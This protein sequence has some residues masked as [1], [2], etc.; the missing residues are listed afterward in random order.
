[1]LS[2][3]VGPERRPEEVGVSS[4]RLAKALEILDAWVERGQVPGVAAVAVRR[5]VVV[6]RHF[7]G[8][9]AASDP[10]QGEPVPI[11]RETI[12]PLGSVTKPI[13]ATAFMLLVEA[14]EAILDD[15]V[16]RFVP[17]FGRFG[18]EQVLLRHLLTHTS[19]LPDTLPN[20]E[21]LRRTHSSLRAF[22]RAA[23][24]QDLAF[25][26]GTRVSYSST[27]FL[28]LTEVA[29]RVAGQAFAD[30]AAEQVFRPLAL[31]SMGF[32]PPEALYPWIARLRLP[33]GRVPTDWDNNSP[34][35]RQLGAP[36][37]GVFATADDVARF[38]QSFLEA[39]RSAGAARPGGA[40][41]VLGP[42]TAR[43]MA[44]NHT[45]D[46][47]GVS[48]TPEAWG[49]G[50]ALP[51]GQPGR[52]AGDLAS[53]ETFGHLGAGRTMLWIDPVRELVC[54]V[55]TNQVTNG[56]TPYRR[57]AGFSNALQAALVG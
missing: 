27:G 10:G 37:G 12:F 4:A 48:G 25:T 43:L 31:R 53:P 57:F 26:P 20:N 51:A 33:E 8:W 14:G 22:V 40:G 55:L 34:Y 30:F 19:G 45:R 13:A 28:M 38:G 47:P 46:I 36:W 24:R 42:A 44:Q 29:E 15:P 6:A 21:S 17:E 50:W 32:R 52:W 54:V 9:A 5:G 1:M 16:A 49:L 18:R 7:R 2:V 35:W 41:V 3:E 39:W 56:P 11:S 23:C